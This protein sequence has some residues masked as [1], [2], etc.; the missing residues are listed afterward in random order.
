M[1]NRKP[2]LGL[3][4]ALTLGVALSLLLASTV[5]A[6]EVSL[7]RV[8]RASGRSVLMPIVVPGA[9]LTLDPEAV[10]FGELFVGATA[11]RTVALQNISPHT[12]TVAVSAP[13]AALTVAPSS[14]VL[15]PQQSATLTVT[16][17]SPTPQDLSGDLVLAVTHEGVASA[18]QETLPVSGAIVL[19][20]Q[21]EVDVPA[22]NLSGVTTI[23][24]G[25]LSIDDYVFDDSPSIALVVRNVGGATAHGVA[26]DLDVPGAPEHLE[27]ALCRGDSAASVCIDPFTGQTLPEVLGDL[28]PG[29]STTVT[30]RLLAG[31]PLPFSFHLPLTAQQAETV[32][33]Q[34]DGEVVPYDL[35]NHQ[36]EIRAGD[37]TSSTLSG[38]TDPLAGDTLS[39]LRPTSFDAR[40]AF[41]AGDF[42]T[43]DLRAGNLTLV[44]PLGGTQHVRGP[45]SYALNAVY[46]SDLWA[47]TG[48]AE[49]NPPDTGP[50][51]VKMKPLSAEYP[52]P[53]YNLR[54]GWALHLGRLF[55]P[56]QFTGIDGDT[57]C[58]DPG[59]DPQAWENHVYTGDR[60]VY[61]DPS[62]TQHELW[63]TPHG[64]AD[65][66]TLSKYLDEPSLYSRDGSYLRLVKESDTVR[67]IEEPGGIRRRF[68]VKSDPTLPDRWL[69]TRIEDRFGNAVSITYSTYEDHLAWIIA[70]NEG[71]SGTAWRK[72]IVEFRDWDDRRSDQGMLVSKVVLP[73]Y[74]DATQDPDKKRAY[75]F[76]Y[77]FQELDH[78]PRSTFHDAAVVHGGNCTVAKMKLHVPELDTIT[79]PDG[80]DL[81]VPLHDGAL[82]GRSGGQGPPPGPRQA[83][84]RRDGV[85]R[86]YQGLG[87]PAGL[88]EPR[89]RARSSRGEPA[90]GVRRRRHHGARRDALPAPDAAHRRRAGGHLQRDPSEQ[91]EP[92]RALV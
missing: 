46:N 57:F 81:G 66:P 29:A 77:S 76:V 88:F 87:Q 67:W 19:P 61:V 12:V 71:V 21:L 18:A 40:T 43:V 39:E 4:L 7:V 34:L 13:T 70:D 16:A 50:G 58:K 65:P 69:L 78:N 23:D 90:D 33:L 1:K 11:S 41:S 10:D 53:I 30:L 73:G 31:A 92:L 3:A 20:P 38:I 47:R 89:L 52:N 36:L 72:T 49:F 24:A 45:L 54:G 79:L 9:H 35:P 60:F 28:A 62:G 82:R 37:V 59:Q 56:F 15:A 83:T 14:L 27:S 32:D 80:S 55:D 85:L 91:L 86:L 6:H 26:L 51:P 63:T 17:S 64:K 44:V 22:W 2:S 42:D 74:G 5:E 48:M 68:E 25:L 75:T 84:E 8:Q